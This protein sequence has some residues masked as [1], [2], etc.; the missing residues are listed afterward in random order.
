[1]IVKIVKSINEDL[2][3]YETGSAGESLLIAKENKIDVFVLD[4]QLEDYSGLKLAE[5]LREIDIYR[6]T[7]I[8]FI[9]GAISK[10]FE[11]YKRIHCYAFIEKPFT[12][13]EV[14]EVLENVIIYGIEKEQ[15]Q[16]KLTLK[17][18]DRTYII[19]KEE[20]IYIER[21]IR[22]LYIKTKNQEIIHSS[23]SLAQIFEQLSDDFAQ[24]HQGFIINKKFI[25]EINYSKNTIY[26]DNINYAIPIGRKYRKDFITL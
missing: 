21:K 8:I 14:R 4:M 19:K 2:N 12:V 5:E 1:A 9:S 23:S 15:E 3:V 20:I 10:E 18:N 11:A 7:P 13:K 22:K 25:R 26:L 6:L 16:L 17:N 24:C